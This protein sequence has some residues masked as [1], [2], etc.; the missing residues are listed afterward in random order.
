MMNS[1]V[2]NYRDIAINRIE[3]SL[4]LGEDSSA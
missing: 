4:T 1:C 3:R 2:K